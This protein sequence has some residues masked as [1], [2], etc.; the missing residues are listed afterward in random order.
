MKRQPV[1]GLRPTQ[2]AIGMSE[3]ERE[4]QEA[5]AIEQ[6]EAGKVHQAESRQGDL[7]TAP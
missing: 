2:F 1:L 6:E 3:V 5:A 4:G 7:R